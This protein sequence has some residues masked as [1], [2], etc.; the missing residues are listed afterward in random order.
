[1]AVSYCLDLFTYQTLTEFLAAG[2]EV[3][4]FSPE[5]VEHR[6]ADEAG[7]YSS[8]LSHRHLPLDWPSRNYGSTDAVLILSLSPTGPIQ[9]K[10]FTQFRVSSGADPRNF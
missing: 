8:L 10:W 7:R 4:G 2:A 9:P 5:A 1:M 6:E 3:S